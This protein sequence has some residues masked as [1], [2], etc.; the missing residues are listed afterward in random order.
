E[1]QPR[2][3]APPKKAPAFHHPASAAAPGQPGIQNAD[4]QKRFDA[5]APDDENNLPEC[6]GHD[7]SFR[8]AF[9]H[10]QSRR[11]RI[12]MEV[13]EEAVLARREAIEDDESGYARADHLLFS[14]FETLELDRAC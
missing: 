3:G 8:F 14:Q 12:G 13:I 9:H 5:L 7:R 10:D 1:G 2:N 11:R 4:D 6:S